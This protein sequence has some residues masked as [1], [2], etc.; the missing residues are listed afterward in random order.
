[1]AAPR[2][3]DI[4]VQ[5]Y[6]AGSAGISPHRD[7]LRY[8]RLVVLLS[9]SGRARLFVC[10]DREGRGAEEVSIAP[11]RLLLMRAPGFAGSDARPFHFLSDV[12]AARYGLG[13]RHDRTKEPGAA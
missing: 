1:M 6:A 13:L 10:D 9:L 8:R 7:H 12:T 5:R 2:L 11:G 3:N 4:A